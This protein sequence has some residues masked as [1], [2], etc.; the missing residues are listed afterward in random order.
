MESQTTGINVLVI[1]KL[2]NFLPVPLPRR[3]ND[4]FVQ[5]FVDCFLHVNR[6]LG[7]LKVLVEPLHH[8]EQRKMTFE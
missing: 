8:Q 4:G 7:R 3:K 5:K 2:S 1:I 6:V